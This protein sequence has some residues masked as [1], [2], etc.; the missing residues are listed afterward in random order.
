[1]GDVSKQNSDGSWSDA[2]PLPYL[3]WKAKCEQFF[4]GIGFVRLSRLF[5]RLDERGLGK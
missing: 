2:E 1:M 5:G 4:L 3:G